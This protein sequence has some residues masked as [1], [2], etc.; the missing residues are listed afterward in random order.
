[1]Q[2]GLEVEHPAC[3]MEL[4]DATQRIESKMADPP[5]NPWATPK[6]SSGGSPW[7]KITNPVPCSLQDVMSEELAAEMV[8]KDEEISNDLSR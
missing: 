3:S 6:T 8:R 7:G 2:S 4:Q 1:M 5:A